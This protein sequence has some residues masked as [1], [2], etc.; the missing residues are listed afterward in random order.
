MK[1][2]TRAFIISLMLVPY[3]TFGQQELRAPNDGD[4]RAAQR[5]Q[6]NYA[7]LKAVTESNQTGGHSW[8]QHQAYTQGSSGS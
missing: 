3:S 7:G 5:A 2:L 1:S 4:K 6:S 8:D